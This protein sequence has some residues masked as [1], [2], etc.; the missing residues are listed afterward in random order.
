MDAAG[1]VTGS[2]QEL[3]LGIDIPEKPRI[4]G[5]RGSDVPAG[6][7]CLWLMHLP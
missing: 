3:V 2:S 7:G 5:R 6:A 1:E 4:D